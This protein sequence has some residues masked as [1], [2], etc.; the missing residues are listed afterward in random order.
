MSKW[1][2]EYS[3][4]GC[5]PEDRDVFDNKTAAKKYLRER[6]NEENEFERTW[7]MGR[8]GCYA[9]EIGDYKL[10]YMQIWELAEGEELWED[11]ESDPEES[12]HCDECGCEVEYCECDLEEEINNDD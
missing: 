6:V 2:F 12:D 9:E 5:L 3:F 1:G 8:D 10:A 7:R 4:P 11:D